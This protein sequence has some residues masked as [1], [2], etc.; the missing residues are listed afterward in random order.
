[1][2][3]QI[4]EFLNK[5]VSGCSAV[6]NVAT[7]GDSSITVE[8]THIL[9]VCNALKSSTEFEFNVL[10]VITGAD[11]ADR[12]EVSYVLASFTKN[13]ELIIKV[14]LPRNDAHVDSVVSVWK[15]ANF[16][17][18]EC[19]DMFGIKFTNHPDKRRILCP[20][21]WKGFPLRK[22]YIV[23]EVY[24]GMVVNPPAKNNT[25]DKMFAK[26]LRAELGNPKLVSG[27]WKVKGETEEV[28]DG[29]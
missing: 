8:A 25:D 22:D 4:V 14:K 17:E 21:D 3:N 15:A 7:V 19:Y 11:Y 28:K 9:A 29:E 20:D 13:L 18:R 1:M 2:H 24:N 12:S 26:N 27:S 16:Q 10:Q 6:V 23:E 5:S